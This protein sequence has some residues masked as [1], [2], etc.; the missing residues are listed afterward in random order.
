MNRNLT[1]ISAIGSF[2]KLSFCYFFLLSFMFF[3]LLQAS[4]ASDENFAL[5]STQQSH[6]G[7]AFE[8]AIITAAR[9]ESLFQ[10]F[11]NRKT[12]KGIPAR[13]VTTEWISSSFKGRDLAEKIRNFIKYAKLEWNLRWVLL[14][15]D[16][17]D[18]AGELIPARYAR[19][20][21]YGGEDIPSD[22]Y[23]SDLDGSWD[24][25]QN[26]TFGEMKDG[27]ELAPD[28]YVGRVSV[29]SESDI[30]TFLKKHEEYESGRQLSPD[31]KLKY[32]FIASDWDNRTPTEN[33]FE[34]IL[35]KIFPANSRKPEIF[36][37]YDSKGT[38]AKSLLTSLNQTNPVLAFIGG[39]GWDEGFQLGKNTY[40]TKS[41]ANALSNSFPF[42][43]VTLSCLTNRFD[44]SV[45]FT[46]HLMRIPT[47]GAIACWGCSRLS[48]YVQGSEG[49]YNNLFMAED[50]LQQIFNSSPENDNRLG[51]Q[52]ARSRSRYLPEARKSDGISRW[53]MLA[54]NLL[55]DPEM[56]IWT[57]AP[58]K[59]SITAALD[60]KSNIVSGKI[61]DLNNKNVS[62]VFITVST[63]GNSNLKIVATGKNIPPTCQVVQCDKQAAIYARA[64]SDKSGNFRIELKPNL[65]VI[66]SKIEELSR[67]GKSIISLEKRI[68]KQHG[69]KYFEPWVKEYNLLNE[70][71]TN[72]RLEARKY[73]IN[74]VE[75]K[76]FD[77]INSALELLK[78]SLK[79][80]PESLYE[81]SYLLKSITDRMRFNLAHLQNAPESIEKKIFDAIL[82]LQRTIASQTPEVPS[83]GQIHVSTT[84][85]NALVLINGV[86]K[87]NS[88]LNVALT[89][90]N[91]NLTVFLDGYK[92]IE[93]TVN[94][95]ASKTTGKN[96]QLAHDF[97]IRGKVVLLNSGAAI[98]AEIAI[99][100]I[101]D[102]ASKTSITT[103]TDANGE[104]EFTNLPAEEMAITVEYPNYLK[105]D[106]WLPLHLRDMGG[107]RNF[108]FELL[109]VRTISV[110]RSKLAD[111][112]EIRFFQK[113]SREQLFKQIA[114]DKEAIQID[115]A[116]TRVV[117][118]R[119]GYNFYVWEKEFSR[120]N[121]PKSD[122][123]IKPAFSKIEDI[124]F[125]Y[126][127]ADDVDNKNEWEF[128]HVELKKKD[129]NGIWS[130][131]L[132]ATETVARIYGYYFINY[133]KDYSKTNIMTT[134]FDKRFPIIEKG[135]ILVN[136]IQLSALQNKNIALEFDPR[137]I[138]NYLTTSDGTSL[139]TGIYMTGQKQ[140]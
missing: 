8:Y 119:P 78:K 83:E 49:A 26:G 39:H 73:F 84:P 3:S 23:F 86:P 80:N 52:I 111:E 91:H 140:P 69:T 33:G 1:H 24:D 118:A 11:A 37:Y 109:P 85:A 19:T 38:T 29:A 110:D 97:C 13:I 88:P 58:R 128:K 72:T 54:M 4:F 20:N 82:N 139:A 2:S 129:P 21:F 7:R 50:F 70:W 90:G 17:K 98:N 95:V 41:D 106:K 121:W 61:S 101:R 35:R 6:N 81:Y 31:E 12:E 87:G 36:K 53:L 133:A 42:V 122:I 102:T 67:L 76:N 94:V 120:L 77:E 123:V 75:K 96:Y 56:A 113:Y 136:D 55:G 28:I 5:S 131:T 104:F 14:G 68:Q 114:K 138:P 59:I 79:E 47:G 112:T 22:L 105:Q 57:S 124:R 64:F 71:R 32:A 134:S 66:L 16:T 103:R 44:S 48:W 9:Y 108:R 135:G 74:L 126:V 89:E 51:M 63:S 107:K 116:S 34:E 99:S 132:I 40:F 25:N 125:S 130:E 10:N 127:N 117:C 93:E 46:E 27:L 15:G 100:S 65:S 92:K 30:I 45:S 137:V 62:G 60:E 18:S 43:Y 115:F